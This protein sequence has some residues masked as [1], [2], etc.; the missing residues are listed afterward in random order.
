MDEIPRNK[1]FISFI[2]SFLFGLL[3]FAPN[4]FVVAEDFVPKITSINPSSI[5]YNGE[6][7]IIGT[8]FGDKT[9]SNGGTNDGSVVKIY[10]SSQGQFILSWSDT[11]VKVGVNN[12]DNFGTISL[13]V[14][15]VFQTYHRV[16][17]NPFP[18]TLLGDCR[19]DEY[20]CG[21]L[22]ACQLDGTQTRNCSKT[23]S[24][25]NVPLGT[26]S[27][28]PLPQT[29]FPCT[30][31]PPACSADTW[32]CGDWNACSAS[33]TQTRSCTKTF[34]CPTAV[35]PSPATTQS[36]TFT[37][38]TCT[39]D[40]WSCGAWD[41]CSPFGMQN[42]SCTKTF[43]CQSV[44][45]PSPSTSQYCTPP[46][47]PQ[48]TCTADTWTCGVW[49][50]CSLSGI[51]SRSCSKTF[52][53]SSVE[54]APPTTSQYC[55]APN[56][57]QQAPPTDSG[58]VTNQDTIVKAT[59]KLLCP[60]DAQRA[61]QG[62]GTIIDSNGIILTNKHVIAGTLGCLVGFINDFNNEPYF[63]QRHIADILR[64]SPNQDVAILK[65]RNP[66]NKTMPSVSITKGSSNLRLGNSV[67]TYGFPAKFGI[68]I[69]YTSGDFSGTD[70]NY[71]KTTAILEY[72]N[73]GGGAYL[74]D[75]TFIGIPSAVVRG[76]LNAL[77]YIL[78]INTINAWL[79]NSTTT[80][81]HTSNNQYSRVS[82]LE[83]IDLETLNSL[84]LF[85]P[86]TD[87]SGDLVIPI[88]PAID[89]KTQNVLSQPQP[90]Q[91]QEESTVIESADTN[92]ETIS[93]PQNQ[94]E[95]E[96]EQNKKV[97]WWKRLFSW[98]IN[99]LF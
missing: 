29:V 52:D 68:K 27:Y 86:E 9:V 67:S 72:G 85:I 16:D 95:Y 37:P 33:G 94:N 28:N 23:F 74:K 17:S 84:K 66:Q 14:S 75:G 54:T 77:G 91:M 15:A 51:Q 53:C 24:C 99:L 78:S 79:G 60:V 34:E 56:R 81:G 96:K 25:P 90:S 31:V 65:I 40:T 39:E 41:S 44:Y 71:L 58:E 3:F 32:S 87:E 1:V 70:G 21:E 49:G 92:Q 36:C 82:V 10:N 76:E 22:G 88:A 93:P 18:I 8:G 97:S 47:P 89:P 61:S 50:E 7:D 20:H 19:G 73:S 64:A 11:N 62:S 35:T 12:S 98:L 13:V 2:F 6:V 45:T 80:F 42:R 83:D 69:T 4:G 55:E 46:P 5:Y 59:V 57:P 48:P 38:P 26:Y 30:Y 43:D 63:G